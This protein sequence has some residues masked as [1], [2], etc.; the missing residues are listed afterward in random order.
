[1]KKLNRTIAALF[2]GSLLSLCAAPFAEA[3]NDKEHKH[4]IC[5]WANGHVHA[6]SIDDDALDTHLVWHAEGGWNA[7]P[8][9]EGDVYL[10]PGKEN[11]PEDDLSCN[12]E[13]PTSTTTTTVPVIP[14]TTTTTTTTPGPTTTTTTVL[15]GTT[16][17]TSTT[18]EPQVV[19]TTPVISTV[20]TPAPAVADPQEVAKP[21]TLPHT[22]FA[23]NLLIF[24]GL[25]CLAGGLAALYLGRNK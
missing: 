3:T 13:E 17:T 18:V 21:V 5:H 16:T 12:P 6:I 22:G 4:T 8:G 20:D 2:L 24:I 7:N 1:M 25:G 19:P 15:P 23:S 10:H 11:K 14:P 9:H